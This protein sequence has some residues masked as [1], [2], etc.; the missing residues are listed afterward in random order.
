MI[1]QQSDKWLL[2]IV[3]HIYHCNIY[4]DYCFIYCIYA[5]IIIKYITV[6][7]RNFIVICLLSFNSKEPEDEQLCNAVLIINNNCTTPRLN[8]YTASTALHNMGAHLG[9]KN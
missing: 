7:I 2:M 9:Y 8:M 6:N 5:C 3:C 4:I 1:F